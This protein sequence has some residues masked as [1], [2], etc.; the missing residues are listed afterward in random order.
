MQFNI[1]LYF[2]LLKFC[3][4]QNIDL[5]YLIVYKLDILHDSFYND[6]KDRH[7]HNNELNKNHIEDV[8]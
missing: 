1:I 2:Y 6:R 8:P 5:V 4:W 7:H 3:N